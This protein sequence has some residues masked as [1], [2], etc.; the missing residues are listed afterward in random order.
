MAESDEHSTIINPDHLTAQYS[1]SQSVSSG[2]QPG[3]PYN[4]PASHNGLSQDRASREKTAPVREPRKAIQGCQ[5]RGFGLPQVLGTGSLSQSLVVRNESPWET[6]KPSFSCRL[7]GTVVIAA[8]RSCFHPSL[9]TAIREY[10]ADDA[11][12]MLHRFR[13]IKHE[14]VLAAREC[15]TGEGTM[16]ALVE[17]LPLTL[18]HLVGCRPIYLG[19]AQLGAIIGQVRQS[20]SYF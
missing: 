16:Y 19:E 2:D 1:S 6:F 14:N 10:S 8:R 3:R 12:K 13:H 20:R 15:F 9:P 18:E 11:D 17:D 7:A 4:L 5:M